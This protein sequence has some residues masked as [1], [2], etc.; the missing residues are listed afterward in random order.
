MPTYP[1]VL[2][3]GVGTG[4]I[5]NLTDLSRPDTRKALA[6][7]KGQAGKIGLQETIEL[8][9]NEDIDI[10]FPP[11]EYY[12]YGR[13]SENDQVIRKSRFPATP[14]A[15][16]AGIA[17]PRL[18]AVTH[19]VRNSNREWVEAPALLGPKGNLLQT[20]IV[21]IGTS[22]AHVQPQRNYTFSISDFVENPLLTPDVFI[23]TH[24]ISGVDAGKDPK[25]YRAAER[26]AQYLAVRS[27]IWAYNE[28][29][30]NVTFVADSNWVRM[31][32]FTA[33]TQQFVNGTIDKIWFCPS[34]KAN[35]GLTLIDSPEAI[36]RY[37]NPSDHDAFIANV[38]LRVNSNYHEV[39]LPPVTPKPVSA[40]GQVAAWAT[41][42]AISVSA[43][44]ELKAI[45]TKAG[46]K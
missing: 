12:H 21:N 39:T 8:E 11:T 33:T 23:D 34:K 29:G 24:F 2:R 37:D 45:L 42:N 10:V 46:V 5:Q 13:A 17:T 18:A 25:D 19:R 9:D 15:R 4:N 44:D 36:E 32:K 22:R 41:K 20:G 28:A 1:T 35:W 40:L 31:P 30:F 27:A 16:L 43:L 14:A 7:L 38:E 26:Q 3:Y 6:S